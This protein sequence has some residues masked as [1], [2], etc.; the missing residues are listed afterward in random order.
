MMDALDHAEPTDVVILQ[1]C[2]HNPTGVD[3]SKSQ[4]TEVSALV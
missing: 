3:L 1:A 4:G 2:A